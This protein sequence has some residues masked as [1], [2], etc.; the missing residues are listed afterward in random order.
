MRTSFT[1]TEVC[2][3]SCAAHSNDIH[4]DTM[5]MHMRMRRPAKPVPPE[6]E[7]R[8]A[9]KAAQQLAYD[10]DMIEARAAYGW[11][12]MSCNVV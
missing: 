5:H 6:L 12:E 10:K 9:Y 4:V 2:N 8:G 11:M 1:M 3:I 7:T